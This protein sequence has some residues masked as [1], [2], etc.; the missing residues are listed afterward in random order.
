MKKIVF[1]LCAVVA[2]S[3]A[4]A[5]GPDVIK[6]GMVNPQTGPN[7]GSGRGMKVG[8]HAYFKAVNEKGGVKGKKL[9]LINLDDQYVTEK[10]IDCLL[11]LVEEHKVLATV[12]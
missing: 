9:E 3:A 7:K 8:V 1:L 2:G 10:T 6:I 4:Y 12:G 11:K 5:A